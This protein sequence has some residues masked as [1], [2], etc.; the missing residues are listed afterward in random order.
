MKIQQEIEKIRDD[1]RRKAAALVA[2]GKSMSAASKEAGIS[3]HA[4]RSACADINGEVPPKQGLDEKTFR[5]LAAIVEPGRK[6]DTIAAELHCSLARVYKILE[7]ARA[8]GFP[9]VP[10]KK[11]KSR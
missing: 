5:I 7:L 2:G 1:A 6:I 4:T 11:R 10:Q 8:A 3:L 9:G